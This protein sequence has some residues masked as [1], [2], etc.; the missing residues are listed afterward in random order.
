MS[1]LRLLNETEVTSNVKT[2][3][4]TDVFTEDFDIYKIVLS[5]FSTVSTDDYY[6]FKLLNNAGTVI[7]TSTYHYASHLVVAHSTFVERRSQTNTTLFPDSNYLS[8]SVERSKNNVIYLFNPYNVSYTFMIN[9]SAS[10]ALG[11][12]RGHKGIG[13]EASETSVSGFRLEAGFIN[14]TTGIFDTGIA[15]TYGLRVDS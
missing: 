7:S 12:L 14:A 5:E 4:I 3:D 9:Q 15:R 11:N 8:T 2:L 1:A 10:N 6:Y 13:M